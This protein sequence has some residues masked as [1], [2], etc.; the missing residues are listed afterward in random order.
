MNRIEQTFKALKEQNRK[1]FIPY[2]MAGDGGLNILAERL[3]TLEK[4][5]ATLI[6]VGVPFS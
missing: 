4:F 3:S 2:I 1:A 5:G 6:E